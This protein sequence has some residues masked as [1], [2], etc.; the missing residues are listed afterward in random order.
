MTRAAGSTC[1]E[2]KKSPTTSWLTG[3]LL[4][5]YAEIGTIQAVMRLLRRLFA[6][7]LVLTLLLNMLTS[8]AAEAANGVVEPPEVGVSLDLSG[9]SDEHEGNF[10]QD[11]FC[12]HSCHSSTHMLGLAF[13]SIDIPIPPH[14]RV[15]L[16]APH[17]IALY[18]TPDKQFRPPRLRPSPDSN[19]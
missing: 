16:T 6:R 17:Q 11:S 1:S 13:A 5:P 8:V 15:S 19:V 10:H 7:L 4:L 14:R 3:L 12:D 9:S 2:I 18:Q